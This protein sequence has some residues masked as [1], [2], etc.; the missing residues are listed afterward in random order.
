MLTGFRHLDRNFRSKGGSIVRSDQTLERNYIRRWQLLIA[1]YEDVKAGRSIAFRSVLEF[2]DHH[3]TCS[4]TFRKFYNRY[5]ASGLTIDLLPQRRGP[6]RRVMSA[7]QAAQTKEA[8][9]RVLHA[10]PSDFGFNRAT[11]KRADLKQALKAS[12]VKLS[13]RDIQS[14]IKAAGYRWM[15]AKKVLTSRDLNIGPSSIA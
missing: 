11:W 5:R 12:G 10:P 15:K 9:F 8:V 6:K 3:G 14:V 4:Q 2:Y 7:I 13:A 1:Q